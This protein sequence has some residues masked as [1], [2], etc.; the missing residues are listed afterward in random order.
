MIERTFG[1]WKKKWMVLNEFP[2][3]DISTQRNVIFATMGLHNFIRWNKIKDVDFEEATME[4]SGVHMHQSENDSDDE[5]DVRGN[6]E[7]ST[8]VYMKIVRDQIATQLWS[9]KRLG[10]RRV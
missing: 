3:Y 7:T 10:S 5:N 9:D 8:A 2:R 6:E 4:N 1:V